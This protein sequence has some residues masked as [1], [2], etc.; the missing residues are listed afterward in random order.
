MSEQR[1][2]GFPAPPGMGPS[3]DKAAGSAPAEVRSATN[4]LSGEGTAREPAPA[5]KPSA[6]ANEPAASSETVP[7][8]EPQ[9]AIKAATVERARIVPAPV[10]AQ[11]ADA[12]IPPDRVRPT[13]NIRI[14]AIA[15]G[16]GIALGFLAGYLTGSSGGKDRGI[17]EASDFGVAAAPA[18]S[19]AATAGAAI[20][21]A[22]NEFV[23][24]FGIGDAETALRGP[25][26]KGQIEQR[27]I[28]MTTGPAAA[29]EI[30][31]TPVGSAYALA[32][33]GRAERL[34]NAESL[35]VAVRLNGK[36][37]TKWQIGGAWEMH[38]TLV[39]PAAFSSGTNRIEFVLP[40]SSAGNRPGL[41]LDSLHVAPLRARA[42]APV[43]GA[44]ARGNLISGFYSKEG[45][46][47][48]AAAWS[49]GKRTRVGLLLAPLNVDYNIELQG[50]AFGPLQPL[51]VE[52]FVNSKSVGSARIDKG[53]KYSYRAPSGVFTQGLNLIEF[54]YPKTV[55]PSATNKASDDNRD[56]A[57]R[58]LSV[59]ASPATA[60]P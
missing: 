8:N 2:P 54:V 43:A 20:E 47:A 12:K 30:P 60:K 36:E 50:Y 34:G 37:L 57:I 46:G 55:K 44:T 1:A 41:A 39:K 7:A 6:P 52:A 24:D 19:L 53:P 56:L 14:A 40:T 18:G 9:A 17:E 23:L 26:T 29:V 25:W 48:Q 13:A 58:L 4:S 10:V 45:Q 59:S 16:G 28:A 38:S 49:A 42:E 31:L 11:P 51:E 3:A 15:A 5:S 27:G 35:D 32:V 33:V 21:Q 22:P